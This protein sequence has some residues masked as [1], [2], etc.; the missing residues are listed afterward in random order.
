MDNMWLKLLNHFQ[1]GSLV[2]LEL[3]IYQ[4]DYELGLILPH[5]NAVQRQNGQ[6]NRT[7]VTQ[8]RG[9]Q[10][11]HRMLQH[12]L[13]SHLIFDVQIGRALVRRR[14]QCGLGEKNCGTKEHDSFAERAEN[15][16]VEAAEC[17][18]VDGSRRY[19]IVIVSHVKI[20]IVVFRLLLVLYFENIALKKNSK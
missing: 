19:Q 17:G 6:V 16:G 2:V 1:N 20:L 18:I 15:D 14:V 7:V 13:S 11:E 9:A 10:A 8:T 3:L 12:D 4:V 5:A